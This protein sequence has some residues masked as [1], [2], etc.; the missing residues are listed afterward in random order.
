MAADFVQQ[1]SQKLK[2]PIDGVLGF[3]FWSKYRVTI[4]YPN[5]RLILDEPQ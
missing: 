3:N 5:R 4:D 1:L 2:T